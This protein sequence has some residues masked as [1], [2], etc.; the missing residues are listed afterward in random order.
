[1]A[2]HWEEHY[3]DFSACLA[4]AANS[5]PGSSTLIGYALAGFGVYAERDAHGNLPTDADLDA[6]SRAD[7]H[8]HV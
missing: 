7:Q 4:T 8:R 6:L 2:Q 1:M 3:H 5:A